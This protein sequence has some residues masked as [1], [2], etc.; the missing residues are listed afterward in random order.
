MHPFL[1]NIAALAVAVIFYAWRAYNDQLQSRK[2]RL[3]RE[4]VAQ[5]LW[6]MAERLEGQPATD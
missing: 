1:G 5:M 4:R 2:Q 6:V 3:L